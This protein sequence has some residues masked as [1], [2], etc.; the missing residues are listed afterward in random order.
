[1]LSKYL[2]SM[3]LFFNFSNGNMLFQSQILLLHTYTL[4]HSVQRRAWI[5]KWYQP[6]LFSSRKYI[7]MLQI[8]YH[9]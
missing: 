3:M 1:M 9:Y 5:Q 7:E 4:L 6:L 8:Y 2:A